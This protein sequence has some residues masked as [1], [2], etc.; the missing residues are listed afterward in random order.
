MRHW[1][2]TGNSNVAIQT[3]ST[4]ISDIVTDTTT[5]PMA[6]LGYSTTAS[7]QKVSTTVYNIELLELYQ[8]HK[9]Q[10]QVQVQVLSLQVRVQVQVPTS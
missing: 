10:V 5:I 6:N 1:R 7:T 3:G 2:T 9:P 8:V 4:C